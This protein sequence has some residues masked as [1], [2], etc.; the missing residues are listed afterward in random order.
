MGRLEVYPRSEPAVGWRYWQL[1]LDPDP[2]LRSLSQRGFIWSPDLPLIARCA[3][4]SRFAG[5]GRGGHRAPEP[6]CGCGIHASVDLASLQ[7]QALCLRPVPLVV[8]KVA[9]WGRVISDEQADRGGQD[10]RGRYAQPAQL[11]VVP[12]TLV[13]ESAPAAVSRLQAY[14]VAVGTMAL[15]E[16]VGEASGTILRH[17]TMSAVTMPAGTSPAVTMPAGTSP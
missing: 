7:A 11:W 14:G 13:G 10:L 15:D 16:A 5:H 6:E 2:R 8:G 1:D 3:D 17:L 4:G 12:E 9:L